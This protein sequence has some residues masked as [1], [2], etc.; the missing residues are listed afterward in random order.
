MRL[1][2]L[3]TTASLTAEYDEQQHC[4][5]LHLEN[6]LTVPANLP[7]S[8]ARLKTLLPAGVPARCL[9]E[10]NFAAMVPPSY[11]H[12]LTDWLLPQLFQVGIIQWLWVCP[13]DNVNLHLAE[14]VQSRLPCLAISTFCDVEQAATW[15]Q[16]VPV[17][18]SSCVLAEQEMPACF[19]H[20]SGILAQAA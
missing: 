16:Q 13:P 19:F 18:G 3:I 11:L 12:W 15:A 2:P 17:S 14:Q 4:L 20:H 8:L 6:F 9:V 10:T 5:F 1:L 7:A